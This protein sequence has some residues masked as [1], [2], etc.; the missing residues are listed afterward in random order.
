[1]EEEARQSAGMRGEFPCDLLGAYWV[2]TRETADPSVHPNNCKL[3]HQP[4]EGRIYARK[5]LQKI[6][7]SN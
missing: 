7:F 2:Q 4:A 6:I 5:G 1:M 3:G